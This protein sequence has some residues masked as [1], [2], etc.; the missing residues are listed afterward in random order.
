MLLWMSSILGFSVLSRFLVATDLCV[1]VLT[2][3]FFPF[4]CWSMFLAVQKLRSTAGTAIWLEARIFQ[5]PAHQLSLWTCLVGGSG[6][7]W[8]FYSEFIVA[9][10]RVLR[11]CF[12]CTATTLMGYLVPSRYRWLG[13]LCTSSLGRRA[14]STLFSGLALG[15]LRWFLAASVCLQLAVRIGY[16]RRRS[17]ASARRLMD[18]SRQRCL[19]ITYAAAL[20][21]VAATSRCSTAT[22][23]VYVLC[24]LGFVARRF[25]GQQQSFAFVAAGF[26]DAAITTIRRLGRYAV[27]VAGGLPTVSWSTSVNNS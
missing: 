24:R 17:G 2:F 13:S 4:S 3:L 19:S 1:L 18:V 20:I 11:W 12:R 25:D 9:C 6:R 15:W 7:S 16:I 27:S 23:A 8:R 22:A 10:R 5:L 26:P 14:F 21:A